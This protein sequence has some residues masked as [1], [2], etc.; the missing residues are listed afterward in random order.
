MSNNERSIFRKFKTHGLSI[1]SDASRVLYGVLEKQ[2]DFNLA[3]RDVISNVRD[4]IERREISS[5]VIS[6]SDIEAVV[7]DMTENEHDLLLASTQVFDAFQNTPLLKFDEQY[8]TYKI[9]QKVSDNA[10]IKLHNDSSMKPTMFRERLKFIE[11]RLLRSG[12]FS[13][14]SGV[15][16]KNNNNN[17]NNI[18]NNDNINNNNNDNNKAPLIE[19]S[20]IESLLGDSG[21][22]LLLG[23]ITQPKEGIWY[24][25]DLG[26]MIPLNLSNADFYS[27]V[28]YTQGSVVLVEG[29]LGSEGVFDAMVIAAPPVEDRESSLKSMGIVDPFGNNMR[30]NQLEERRLIEEQST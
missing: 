10:N 7:L 20:S 19:I 14:S 30:A 25:E 13:L 22:K 3:L 21:T 23:Y 24:L 8:K 26:A 29:K 12:R 9:Q 1:Q 27:K 16:G 11:Q 2:E 5:S 18:N 17:T 15:Q 28:L 4:R 6:S